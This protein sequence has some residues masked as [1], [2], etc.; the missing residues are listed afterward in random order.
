MGIAHSDGVIEVA[1]NLLEPS[2]VGGDRVQV[3]VERLA[4]EE[5]FCP[6]S[7][8]FRGGHCHHLCIPGRVAIKHDEPGDVVSISLSGRAL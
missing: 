2:E 8:A 1:C 6:L 7:F 5:V 3:E 4:K